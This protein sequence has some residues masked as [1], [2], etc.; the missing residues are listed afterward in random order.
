MARCLVGCGSNLGARRDFLDR[1]VE[2]LR[3]MPGI[4]V[5]RVSRFRDTRPIGGPPGQASFLNGACLLETEL[6]PREVLDVLMAVENTL[7]RERQERWG[8]RTV[9]LDLLLYDEQVLDTAALTVPHPRMAT[10][11][12]VLEPSVEIAPDLVHPLAGCTLERLLESISTPHPHVA[13]VGAPGSGAEE[14]AAAVAQATMA[15][16]VV[17]PP[18]YAA[19]VRLVGG[20]RRSQA[21]A[22]WIDAVE[23]AARPLAASRWPKDPHGTVTDYWLHTLRL[24]AESELDPEPAELFAAGFDAAIRGTVAPQVAIL[25]VASADLLWE[26]SRRQD[27]AATGRSRGVADED[28][29]GRQATACVAEESRIEGLGRLQERLVAALRGPHPPERIGPRAVVTIAA[30][31][32]GQAIQE[33][34]AAVEA[35]A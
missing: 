6:G 31:D 13:V 25:L 27:D 1:A 24:A 32:L 35:L 33:A 4:R 5:V 9:D 17:A 21:A 19:A 12:F 34:V 10:R 29:G 7:Q 26:R 14:V 28:R 18:A 22:A 3:Y 23:A 16:L 11:R 20:P 30:D 15:R 8:P 2:L